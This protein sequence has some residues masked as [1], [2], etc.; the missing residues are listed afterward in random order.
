MR[1][2]LLI[3]TFI[4]GSSIASAQEG[5]TFVTP[6]HP[7]PRAC[8][9]VYSEIK[10]LADYGWSLGRQVSLLQTQADADVDRGEYEKA[11]A[12]ESDMWDMIHQQG[13]ANENQFMLAQWFRQHCR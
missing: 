12:L 2:Y 5:L 13:D 9:N 11:H 6:S 8:H 7:S 4:L 1:N 10:Q 3:L